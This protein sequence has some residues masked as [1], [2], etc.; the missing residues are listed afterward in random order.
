MLNPLS[1]SLETEET[2]FT[3][4]YESTQSAMQ[5]H[6]VGVNYPSREPV[7]V[8]RFTDKGTPGVI[9]GRKAKVF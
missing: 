5:S 7:R 1:Y 8:T 4:C 9:L 6:V 3:L 2:Q